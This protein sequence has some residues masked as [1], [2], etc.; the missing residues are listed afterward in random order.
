[1]KSVGNFFDQASIIFSLGG[2]GEETK[3]KV[4]DAGFEFWVSGKMQSSGPDAGSAS[5][6][7][8]QE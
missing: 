5:F 6:A 4:D 3:N 8:D 7:K 2:Y 1:M